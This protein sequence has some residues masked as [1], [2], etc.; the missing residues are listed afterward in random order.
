M[1]SQY[2]SNI[3]NA[4]FT[5]LA[6]HDLIYERIEAMEWLAPGDEDVMRPLEGHIVSFLPFHERGLTLPPHHFFHGLH[7]Y[8]DIELQHLTP[9]G[10]HHRATLVTLYEEF[11]GIEPHFEL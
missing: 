10:I 5:S 4:C 11:L 7:H 6:S 8:Y 9:N 1:V 3:T 2:F